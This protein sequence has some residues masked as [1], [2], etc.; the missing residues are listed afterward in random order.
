MGVEFAAAW[1]YDRWN[2]DEAV[3]DAIVEAVGP[4]TR[5]RRDRPDEELF[6]AG[7]DFPMN[8]ASAVS[9]PS[10]AAAR[11]RK[12]RERR[13]QGDVI[14]SLKLGSNE[15]SDLVALGWMPATT[16]DGDD[17]IPFAVR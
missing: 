5:E 15:I 1:A 16:R 8:R 6:G 9:I 14:A 2:G 17:K 11:M 12:S 13:R 7:A 4:F 3:A 10:A